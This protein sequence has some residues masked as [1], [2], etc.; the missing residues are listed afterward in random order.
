MLDLSVHFFVEECCNC[1]VLFAMTAEHKAALNR[2]KE[3]FYCPNGH[4]QHYMG[5]S[6]DRMLREAKEEAAR[7]A[8]LAAAARRELRD[9]RAAR[10]AEQKRQA[11]RA[12]AGVCR[13]CKRSFVNVQR[14]VENKH[15]EH[16]HER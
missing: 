3:W 8:E 5:K 14:H 7:Q 6:H 10:E 16:A 2:T 4:A 9:E 12:A 15:P 11:R 13:W 1:H